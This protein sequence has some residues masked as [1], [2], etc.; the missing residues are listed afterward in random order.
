MADSIRKEH[1]N[2]IVIPAEVYAKPA[3]IVADR[4]LT[5]D[6]KMTALKNWEMDEK[7]ALVAD[8]ENMTAA[9]GA[10]PTPHETVLRKIQAAERQLEEGNLVPPPVECSPFLDPDRPGGVKQDALLLTALIAM[11]IGACIFYRKAARDAADAPCGAGFVALEKMHGLA[12]T[13]LVHALDRNAV[14][15][16]EAEQLFKERYG[17]FEQLQLSGLPVL[18]RGEL[19]A[20]ERAEE[21]CYQLMR[22]KMETSELS[23]SAKMQLSAAISQLQKRQATLRSLAQLADTE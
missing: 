13:D 12:V 22:E 11:N 7:A 17:V 14:G 23:G 4:S 16:A 19:A 20:I 18:R 3:D 2:K 9:R 10:D 15:G 8:A 1:E 6:E 5:W 21:D